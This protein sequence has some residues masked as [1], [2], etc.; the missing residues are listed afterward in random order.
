M[1]NKQYRNVFLLKKVL[2]S[3]IKEEVMQI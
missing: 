1:Q 2:L 3:K